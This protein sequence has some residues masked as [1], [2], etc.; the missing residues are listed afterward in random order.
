MYVM[1]DDRHN[2]NHHSG[3]IAIVHITHNA[4]S[5]LLIFTAAACCQSSSKFSQWHHSYSTS[6][7][8]CYSSFVFTSVL[9]TYHLIPVLHCS[10]QTWYTANWQLFSTHVFNTHNRNSSVLI[11]TTAL[12]SVRWTKFWLSWEGS[13]IR[14]RR[15]PQNSLAIRQPNWHPRR[16]ARMAAVACI[17]NYRRNCEDVICDGRVA[18]WRRHD[19]KHKH[20]AMLR[21]IHSVLTP[22]TMLYV[23]RTL[24]Q[25]GVCYR[26]VKITRCS[27]WMKRWTWKWIDLAAALETW[28]AAAPGSRRGRRDP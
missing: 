21:H 13:T 25:N 27:T 17:M 5:S 1:F 3:N 18:C 19:I 9:F 23:C 16:A 20:S 15:P 22:L 26:F 10:G 11:F 4:N 7:E 24:E 2:T 14:G 12:W 6:D 28:R 8:C